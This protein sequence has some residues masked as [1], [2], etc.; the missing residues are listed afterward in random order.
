[1]SA[2]DDDPWRRPGGRTDL[3]R[4]RRFAGAL[5]QLQG[6]RRRLWTDALQISIGRDQPQRRDIKVRRRHDANDA[7]RGGPDPA[8]TL[9]TMVLAQGLGD[10]DRQALWLEESDRGAG[11]PTGRDHAPHLG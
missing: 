4:H 1:M 9:D 6:R 2:T 11:A 3:S 10:A 7:L 5:S 8:G